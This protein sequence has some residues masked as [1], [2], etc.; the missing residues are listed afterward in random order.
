MKLYYIEQ[1]GGWEK[2][3]KEHFDANALFDKI[4]SEIVAIN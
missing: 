2:A 3:Q 1:L 4:Y